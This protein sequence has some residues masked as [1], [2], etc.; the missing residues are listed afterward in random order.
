[1][2]NGLCLVCIMSAD[3]I[4]QILNLICFNS[5]PS[6]NLQ[7]ALISDKYVWLVH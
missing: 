5:P 7:F 3:L 6:L 2:I 4:A 1:M